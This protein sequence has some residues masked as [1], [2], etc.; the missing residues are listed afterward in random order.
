MSINQYHR[1]GVSVAT[2]LLCTP[3]EQV[4]LI[5]NNAKLLTRLNMYEC[6]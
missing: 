5:Q 3:Q 2:S 1:Q 4:V 6:S